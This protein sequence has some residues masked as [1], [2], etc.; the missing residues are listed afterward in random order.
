MSKFSIPSLVAV[1]NFSSSS[2][3]MQS[4]DSLTDAISSESAISFTSITVNIA[5]FTLSNVTVTYCCTSLKLKMIIIEF[6]NWT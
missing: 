2:V 6:I 4:L 5:A 1:L 3:S